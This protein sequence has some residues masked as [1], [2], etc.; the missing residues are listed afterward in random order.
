MLQRETNFVYKNQQIIL[1]ASGC[2][3]AISY[4]EMIEEISAYSLH[5]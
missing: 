5:M 1:N 3:D 2:L 4:T